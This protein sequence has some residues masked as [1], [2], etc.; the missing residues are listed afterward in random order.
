MAKY[1]AVLLTCTRIFQHWPLR[2]WK[3]ASLMALKSFSSLESLTLKTRWMQGDSTQE[4]LLL[5]LRRTILGTNWETTH[6]LSPIWCLLSEILDSALVLKCI[7]YCHM[8]I[9]S[10]ESGI[11]SQREAG[12]IPSG[13]ERHILGMLWWSHKDPKSKPWVLNNDDMKSNLHIFIFISAC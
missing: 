2:R 5:W 13:F 3:L 4:W 8:W 12:E 11:K 10:W 7:N 1:V 9:V 6:C